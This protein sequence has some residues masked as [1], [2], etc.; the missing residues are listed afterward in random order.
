M[1]KI[2]LNFLPLQESEFEFKI[3]R[4]KIIGSTEKKEGIKNYRLYPDKDSSERGNYEVSLVELNEYEEFV[5]NSKHSISLT[6]WFI[7]EEVKKSISKCKSDINYYEYKKG[8]ILELNFIYSSFNEGNQIITLI[9][10]FLSSEKAFGFII[11]FSFRK[12]ENQPFNKKIQQLSLSLDSNFRS[13]KNYYSNKNEIFNHFLDNIFTNFNFISLSNNKNIVSKSLYEIDSLSLE[14][15]K[16]IFSKNKTSNS[17]FMGIKN[18]GPYE[19]VNEDIHFVFVF[20][21]RFTPFANDLYLSLIGKLHPGTFPGLESMF[22]IKLNKENVQKIIIEDYTIPTLSKTINQIIKIANDKKILTVFIEDYNEE[23]GN[24]Q[25]YYFMKYHFV[26]ND[27]PL[28]VVNYNRL[29][30]N[31]TLKWSASNLGLQI[32]SKLGG[33]PWIVN[34]S[35]K[36]CLILGIGSSHKINYEDHSIKKYFAYSVCLDSSGLYKKLEVLSESESEEN[37]LKNLE[38]SLLKMLNMTEFNTYKTCVLHLPFKIKNKEI[39]SLKKVIKEKSDMDFVVAKVNVKNSFFG[40]SDHNT[41]VPYESSYI[42]LN[43]DEFLVWF[44]GLQ[45]GKE[46]VARQISNPVHIKFL[47]IENK[48]YQE[49]YK[50]YLQDIINL[51]GANWRGFNAKSVPISIFYSKLITDYISEFGNIFEADNK[52]ISNKK[53]W[54]L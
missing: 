44:E 24:S 13:N 32:F 3:Y 52:S 26:Q 39:D 19:S 4:K 30:V 38:L 8:K 27:I 41:L 51:S 53:P 40:F 28:Q 49:D 11:D 18:I 14:K 46:N 37:Y 20:E 10:Y 34:P 22:G 31:N 47:H 48:N 50:P 6:K 23:E 45:Y 33:K 17:Q 25:P 1:N 15:K 5:I 29:S 12:N 21:K 42:S 43:N 54:F 9:P 36:N 2:K 16:Y 7:F 35:K